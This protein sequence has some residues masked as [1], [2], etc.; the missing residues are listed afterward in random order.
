[1]CGLICYANDDRTKIV[2]KSPESTDI[3]AIV[4]GEDALN[5]IAEILGPRLETTVLRGRPEWT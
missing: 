4:P 2:L 3:A 5:A 1:M